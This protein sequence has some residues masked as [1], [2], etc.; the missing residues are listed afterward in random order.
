MASLWDVKIAPDQIH[1]KSGDLGRDLVECIKTRETTISP[2]DDAVYSDVISHLSDIAI[3]LG[4]K[5]KWDPA[6]EQII[7]D[8]E[9]ARMLTRTLRKPWS[10]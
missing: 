6:K 1:L 4:R 5:I 9:A 7:G 3:R 10:V 8:E 2:I